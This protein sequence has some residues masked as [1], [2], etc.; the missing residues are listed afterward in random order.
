MSRVLYGILLG[1]SLM[2]VS[3][4][5][6]AQGFQGFYIG[7]KGGVNSSSVLSRSHSSTF[8]A[9]EAGYNFAVSG[10]WILGADVWAD[11]HR[12]SVTGRDS[13]LDAKLGYLDDSLMY[14]LK[15]GVAGT[16]P[17]KRVHYG[18]GLEFKFSRHWGG[19]VEWTGDTLSRGATVYQNNNVVAGITL[20][21]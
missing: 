3:Q 10:N 9:G 7:A 8:A 1:T 5:A 15:L 4:M 16:T 20:H 12:E 6:C 21:F 18:W 2:A 19:L 11:D 13:G 17:G 14:Y